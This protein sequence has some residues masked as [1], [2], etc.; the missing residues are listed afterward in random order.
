MQSKKTEVANL[1]LS[2]NQK[3][4]NLIYSFS[5]YPDFLK[6]IYKRDMLKQTKINRQ[7]NEIMTPKIP[8][9]IPKSLLSDGK[10]NAKTKKNLRTTKILYL[11]PAQ[12]NELGV[13]L[14]PMASKGCTASC[15]F[16]AGMGV[17]ANVKASRLNRTHYYLQDRF[18]F[19]QHLA[20][21]IVRT[22]NRLGKYN[23]P[24]AVRLNGTS[25]IKLVEQLTSSYGNHIPQN[26]V[27]YDYTKIPKKA[28][29][30]TLPSG[31]RYQV[32]FSL[33]EDNWDSFME[34]VGNKTAIGAAVF[35]VKKDQ[36][37]PDFYKGM[38]VVDGDSRDDLMLDVPQ[39]T[40]LGLRAKGKALK[41]KS[42]FVIYNF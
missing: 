42:G 15:L 36:P 33:S 29:N 11:A 20:L 28:G 5:I 10:S 35:A 27:F 39:G 25:D 41:D 19:V 16:T 21:E 22:A 8:F 3:L 38:P 34:L 26:V 17:Y 4:T 1:P 30:Y 18:T 6:G 12:Q 13:N 31:H 24:L 9:T 14:C 7:T 32:A 40:I 37:L 23:Q 2:G